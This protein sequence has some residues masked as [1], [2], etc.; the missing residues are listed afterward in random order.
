MENKMNEIFPVTIIW[1]ISVVDIPLVTAAFVVFV[2]LRREMESIR[3]STD[4]KLIAVKE[5]LADFKLEVAQT[6]ASLLDLKDVEGRLIAH[7]L[8]IESKLDQ[9][10]LKAH[11]L[12]YNRNHLRGGETTCP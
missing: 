10:A 5:T 6:Y 4:R 8:R 12:H 1:W 11:A 2:K 7:L 3:A 9:T